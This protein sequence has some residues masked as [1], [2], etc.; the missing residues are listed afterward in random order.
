MTKKPDPGT[1]AAIQLAIALIHAAV[2]VKFDDATM[3]KRIQELQDIVRDHTT[4]SAVAKCLDVSWQCVRQNGVQVT[5]FLVIV[6]FILDAF[7][8]GHPHKIY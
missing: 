6:D 8:H 1:V 7:Q 5:D 2:A 4:A 3:R